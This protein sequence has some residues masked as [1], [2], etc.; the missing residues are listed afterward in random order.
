MI[1]NALNRLIQ[2]FPN[3]KTYEI[4]LQQYNKK[5]KNE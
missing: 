3:N 1:K 5:I 2:M 4:A